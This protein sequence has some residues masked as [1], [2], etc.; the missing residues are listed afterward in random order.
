MVDAVLPVPTNG[1]EHMIYVF[2]GTKYAKIDFEKNKII[3][4]G[5]YRT[6]SWWTQIRDAGF[7][8]VDAITQVP[9]M[10]EDFYVFWGVNS[11]SV[12]SNMNKI[13]KSLASEWK[14]LVD[15]GFHTVGAALTDPKGR[16]YIYFFL[17]TQ[18]LQY[19]VAGN[20]VAWGPHPITE[21]WPAL[22]KAGFD[23]VDTVFHRPGYKD[24]F[25]VVR[26]DHYI[27]MS[28]E[29]D[30]HAHQTKVSGPAVTIESQWKS[31]ESS[32]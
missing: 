9:N 32:V 26:G 29:G 11:D 23:R 19:D 31:L 16:H 25:Y 28:W 24:R 7:R 12:A 30:G 21:G 20:K 15:A 27:I 2:S 1:S 18:I 14:P 5:G 6:T 8:G 13:P 3:H 22:G 10:S 4:G 17:G